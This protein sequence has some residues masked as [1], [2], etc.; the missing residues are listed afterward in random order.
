MNTTSDTI[1][2][3]DNIQISFTNRKEKSI[4]VKNVSFLLKKGETLAIVGESGSGKTVCSLAIMK[5]LPMP[6]AAIDN[7]SITFHKEESVVLSELSEKGI[8]KYR[9]A[10]IAMI[11]QEPM[12]ALNPSHRCGRQV[13]EMLEIHT[14]YDKATIKKKVLEMFELVDLPQVERIYNAY[15]HQL[16]GG[17]LQRVMIAMSII[18]EPDILI[19]DEPTTA[20]DVTVQEKIVDLL[21]SLKDR[22]G[23][24]TIFITHDLGLVRKIADRVI[25]MYKGEIVEEGS[26]EDIFNHPKASYTKGLIACRPP[27]DV[28]YTR[29]PTIEDFV[30]SEQTV[31]EVITPLIQSQ[32]A[33]QERLSE[34]SEREVILEATNIKKYFPNKKNFWGKATSWVKAV[35]D[36]SFTLRRGETLGLVGESG[37]GKSTLAKV[38]LRLT[39]ATAGTVR[40]QGRDLFS[41]SNEEMRKTRKDYQIIF[42]DPY[43]SLNPRM[44]IGAAILEPMQ[45]HGIG[46]NKKERKEMVCDILEKVGLET[47]FYDRYPHQFS[48][49]QR[50][51]ICI[52]RAIGLKPKFI[53]CDESVSALDVSV[54]A[55]VLNLLKDLQAEYDLSY[56]FI[57]H[58]L[59]VVKFISDHILV[60][61]DGKIVERG[62]TESIINHSQHSYTQRL[63]DAIPR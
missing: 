62:N 47:D 27:L 23:I 3:V 8:V 44:K 59:S 7:G 63:I 4:A 22:L 2:K 32:S 20:L 51:R 48:G 53:L 50:Q 42:Q 46:S 21:A 24:S 25:V 39:D 38:L 26:V 30:D 40:F 18:C 56:V 10:R 54:Q 37:C 1:L 43:G 11:F 55:Q 41:L 29:L 19:A 16:S 12:S 17:Q 45:I 31:S 36:V 6:P 58:D 5:L 35:D 15:P 57:S 49:G 9:G 33:Y 28:R 60:M 14:D 13:E 52:A 34:I 61:K